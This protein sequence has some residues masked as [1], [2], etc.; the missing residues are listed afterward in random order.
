MLR[1]FEGG[2]GV[3]IY[4]SFQFHHN[5]M[6]RRALQGCHSGEGTHI[7]FWDT[8]KIINLW[9]DFYKYLKFNSVQKIPP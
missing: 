2:H 5:M 7:T 9:R 1:H 4:F 6:D 8:P 3:P